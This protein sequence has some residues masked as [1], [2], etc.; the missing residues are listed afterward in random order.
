MA[1]CLKHMQHKPCPDC[2]INRQN[3]AYRGMQTSI[4]KVG[5]IHKTRRNGKAIEG[6]DPLD[7]PEK[8]EHRRQR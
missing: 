8:S 6:E 4:W 2:E 3:R 1:I 7:F 5:N